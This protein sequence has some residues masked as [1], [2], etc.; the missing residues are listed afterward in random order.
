MTHKRI[1]TPI[2]FLAFTG[3]S[4][5]NFNGAYLGGSL[6]INTQ[7]CDYHHD[8]Q[9]GNESLRMNG[10][11][12]SPTFGVFGGYGKLFKRFYL[13]GEVDVFY[14]NQEIVPFD[15]SGS[16]NDSRTLKV[17]TKSIWQSDVSIRIGYLIKPEVMLYCRLGIGYIPWEAKYQNI[18]VAQ[19][20]AAAINDLNVTKKTASYSI[21]TGLGCDILFNNNGF[22]RLDYRL[23]FP[24]RINAK[25]RVE[26]DAYNGFSGYTIDD[27]T[28]NTVG[29]LHT[30]KIYNQR[31]T[32]GVG[33]RF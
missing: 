2:I 13:G 25:Q 8:S 9:S 33:Y 26:V 20:T 10:N 23:S 19:T 27:A 32:V 16:D 5:A 1:F 15:S 31:I 3:I 7:G 18:A 29:L 30:Q 21:V 28:N 11:K 12:K 24:I 14:I 4:D 17:T 22:V 6:G